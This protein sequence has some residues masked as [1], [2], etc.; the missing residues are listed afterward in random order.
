EFL[1]LPDDY[2]I[3]THHT[4]WNRNN[5]RIIF[6]VRGRKDKNP[7]VGCVIHADGTGLGLIDYDGHPEWYE[8]NLLSLPGESFFKLYNVDTKEVEG[9][10]GEEGMFSSPGGDNAYSPDGKWYVG[11]HKATSDTRAYTFYRMEDGAHFNSPEILTR[12]G[13]GTTRIDGAPRWNRA[14][15]AILVGGLDVDGSRQV[16]VIRMLPGK[17]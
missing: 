5:D 10:I 16:F 11:S 7:N 3:Y 15:N 4:L 14:C 2:P 6:V 8:G 13:G 1:D 17:E 9:R 12:D